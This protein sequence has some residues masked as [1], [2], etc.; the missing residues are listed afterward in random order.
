VTGLGEMKG[1]AELT[2]SREEAEQ[3]LEA[4]IDRLRKT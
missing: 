1:L 2:T 3:A 4:E